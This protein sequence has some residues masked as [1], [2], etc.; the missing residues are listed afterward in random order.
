MSIW[1]RFLGS[2]MEGLAGS[3]FF[4]MSIQC[5]NC[6]ETWGHPL[7]AAVNLVDDVCKSANG[8]GVFILPC[9][10]GYVADLD[11]DGEILPNIGEEKL[12]LLRELVG[13]R[14]PDLRVEFIVPGGA[15]AVERILKGI[16]VKKVDKINP[17]SREEIVFHLRAGEVDRFM[18]WKNVVD[19]NDSWLCLLKGKLIGKV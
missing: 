15:E 17:A 3:G 10:I 5:W 19:R 9:R 18:T 14:D 11:D 12:V 13:R 2:G 4:H 16:R 1:S 7:D 8:A 6:R